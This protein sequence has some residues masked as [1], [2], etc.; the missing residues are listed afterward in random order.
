MAPFLF[1]FLATVFWGISYPEETLL[2]NV[3]QLT[4]PTMGFQEAGEAYFSPDGRM[5]SFQQ[6]PKGETGYQISIMNLDTKEVRQVSHGAEACTCSFFRPDGKKIIFAAS[7]IERYVPDDGHYHWDRTPYTNIYEANVDGSDAVAL[8]EGAAYHAE[9]GY[10]PDGSHIV[11]ASNE[12]GSMN[13]YTMRSDGTDV[14]QLT[15]TTHCY[16]GGSFFSPDGD[17]N[18]FQSR[19]RSARPY[20]SLYHG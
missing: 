7:P 13:I 5:I 8:T 2:E 17:K 9:C 18:Y 14:K 4:F 20:A 6:I 3:E 11:Y 19:Q 12:D 10:S 16:N 15:H 1:K